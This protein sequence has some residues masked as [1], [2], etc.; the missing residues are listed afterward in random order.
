MSYGHISSF[1]II[2][3]IFISM[4]YS[5]AINI[6]HLHIEVFTLLMCSR[7]FQTLFCFQMYVFFL[8]LNLAYLNGYITCNSKKA[9][10]NI[11][12]C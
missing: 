10:I 2:Y 5:I 9:A 4:V 8:I 7:E 11:F 3:F 1:V 12:I 6:F